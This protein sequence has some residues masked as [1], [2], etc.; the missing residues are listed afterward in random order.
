MLCYVQQEVQVVQLALEDLVFQVLPTETQ[1]KLQIFFCHVFFLL[2]F[3]RLHLF[4]LHHLI[5]DYPACSCVE[6]QRVLTPAILSKLTG[7]P[8]GPVGPTCAKD[9]TDHVHTMTIDNTLTGP[10][11]SGASPGCPVG[12]LCISYRV[13]S[14]FR[15]FFSITY[16]GCCTV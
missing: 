16:N 10:T 11:L 3:P 15:K 4:R 6:I 8:C 9:N 1:R 13:T 12:P 7:S 14:K 5:Q 2:F